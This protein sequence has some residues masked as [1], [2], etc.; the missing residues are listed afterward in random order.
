MKLKIYSVLMTVALVA[1]SF[2][3]YKEH[4]RAELNHLRAE[5]EFATRHKYESVLRPMARTYFKQSFGKNNLTTA[6]LSKHGPQLA[7]VM[8]NV[9]GAKPWPWDG[10]DDGVFDK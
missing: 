8:Y 9:P 2:Y 5:T 7:E 1:V 6:D 4:A 10:H 3:A